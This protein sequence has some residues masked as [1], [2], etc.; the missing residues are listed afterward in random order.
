MVS[1]LSLQVFTG[2]GKH[3]QDS[4]VNRP[5]PIFLVYE[6]MSVCAKRTGHFFSLAEITDHRRPPFIEMPTEWLTLPA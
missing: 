1:D 5:H 4:I 6:A 2:N 3:Q